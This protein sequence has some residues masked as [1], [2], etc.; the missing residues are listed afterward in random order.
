MKIGS[1]AFAMA[2]EF[3]DEIF[4]QKDS[5]KTGA[6]GAHSFSFSLFLINDHKDL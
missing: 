1:Q 4:S 6:D 5:S 3:F 2:W